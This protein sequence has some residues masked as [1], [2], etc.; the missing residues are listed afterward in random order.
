MNN[1][2]LRIFVFFQHRKTLLWL[3]LVAVSGLLAFSALR[4][5]F[6]EDI[7]SFLP[8]NADNKRINEAYQKIGAAN[9]IIVTFSQK[10]TAQGIDEDLLTEAATRFS[11]ILLKNDTAKHIKD[12]IYEVDNEKI[13]E[14]TDFITQNLPYFLEEEDYLR[15][16]S[17]IQLQN[18]ENQLKADK[19]LLLSPMGGFVRNVILND[20]LHFSQKVLKNLEVFKQSDNYNTD[21]GF[22][23]NDKGECI[24]TISSNH[25]IGET[26][27]N[28][29]LANEIY[30]AVNQT[31]DEYNKEIKIVPFGAVLI[32]ITNAD[33]IKKDSIISVSIALALILALLL[34]FFRNIKSL[35]FIAL[36]IAFG[37]LFSLG[38][39]VL[40]KSTVS[41]IAIG[42]ASIIFGIAIN[43]PLHF[44]AHFRHNPDIKQVIKEIVNPLLIGNITTVGAFLSLLFISSDAMKDLGLFSSFLLVGTIV[45]VLIFLPHLASLNSSKGEK[46]EGDKEGIFSRLAE[47]SPEKNK[48]IV[49]IFLIFT[50][51]LFFFSFGTKF[52][53]NLQVINYMTAEQR[54]EMN[55]L[56]EQN[57]VVG[58][59]LYVVAEGTS[60]EGALGYN[61]NAVFPIVQDLE[62]D[63]LIIGYS[64]IG[65]FFLPG[66]TASGRIDLWNEFWK[67]RKDKFLKDFEQISQQQGFNKD[68]FANFINILNN[69][70]GESSINNYLE[71]NKLESLAENYI[72]KDENKVFIFTILK[73]K[74]EHI[75]ETKT[76]IDNELGKDGRVFTFDDSSIAQKLVQALSNDFNNV[77]Y[78]CGIIVF[79]FLFFTFGQIEL[80]VLTFIPLTIGWIWILG[81]MNIFDLKFNIVNIILATFIFGQGDDYTIFVTEGLI[82]EYAYRKKMLAS[83]KTSILLSAIILFIGI[84]MLIFA[85]HPAMRSLAELTIVGMISVVMCAYL[86]PPLI[87]RFLT[88]KKGKL[89]EVP[90]TFKRFLRMT[91]AFVIFLIGSLLTTIYGFILLGFRKRT[92]EKNKLRYHRL[93]QWVADFVI[94]RVPGVKFRYENLSGE[95]FDKPAVIISNHQ[96]HLDLM[97]LM[98]LTPKLII[99]TNDWVWNSPFYGRLIKYADFYPVS[100]GIENSLEQL[101]EAVNRGYSIVIFPEGTRSADCNIGRFHR[102]AFYLAEKLGLDILPVFL[103]GVGHVLPKNDFLL[104]DGQI[105]VQVHERI[106]LND[107][108]FASDYSSRAKQVRQYYRKTYAEISQK[109]ETLDYFKSFVLHN[110]MYKGIDIWRGAKKEMRDA[111][112]NEQYAIC[113]QQEIIIKNN[114]YGVYSFLFALANKNT[115]VIAEEEDEEKVVI[116]KNCAG[117][118]KNLTIL[119]TRYSVRGK[120]VPQ[121]RDFINRR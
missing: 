27:N 26:E 115:Q 35:F 78:I 60:F 100:Q 41:I 54:E 45:F 8:N 70:Y 102:G 6:V 98:M 64:G 65:R 67:N 83:F 71:N 43:Y 34:Y 121:G 29:L 62:K 107:N 33:Q 12:L 74:P 103:H 57:K 84:G 118:P 66:Q 104:R 95:T 76:R 111:M 88:T 3:L 117:I 113:D 15:I 58:E 46:H 85:K 17:L 32:S 2:F 116:A 30:R 81:L 97:C 18:V 119:G 96:S 87:F 22:I 82:Y 56:I 19:E 73:C 94:R 42:V 77:L 105:T 86:F 10:D 16:D 114:G 37:A 93:L 49:L 69:D 50:I 59:T 21:N 24:V 99:L 1:L 110:Y 89:R 91:Y 14:V 36:S 31:I 13:K 101:S 40:F 47:F 80:A 20:P 108:R 68:V 92:N 53:T 5:S 39:I 106:L 51:V 11:E 63:S 52:E 90:W 120:H 61:N 112:C 7:S 55:K 48:L 72:S 75:K 25:S 109:I 79:V 28:K 44:L 38:V 9:K 23:I 4:I